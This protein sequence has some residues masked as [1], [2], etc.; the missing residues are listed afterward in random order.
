MRKK[1]KES[2]INSYRKRQKIA[3]G[4]AC[5]KGISGRRNEE[6]KEDEKRRKRAGFLFWNLKGMQPEK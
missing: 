3:R 6:E 1:A 2:T 4:N 5:W